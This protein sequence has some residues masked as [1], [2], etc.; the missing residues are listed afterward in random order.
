MLWV[1]FTFND[2]A[3]GS[4]FLQIKTQGYKDQLLQIEIM[5][6]QSY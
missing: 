3:V 5:Q 6:G 2:V 1:N 4:Q